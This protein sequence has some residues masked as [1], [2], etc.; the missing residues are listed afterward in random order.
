MMMMQAL[1]DMHTKKMVH[2][3]VKI[4]N[5][6]VAEGEIYKVGVVASSAAKDGCERG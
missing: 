3:D 5:V 6:L 4:Q 2:M 1:H